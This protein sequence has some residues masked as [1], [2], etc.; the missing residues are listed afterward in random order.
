MDDPRWLPIVY[1]LGLI[2]D[3]DE[4]KNINIYDEA[5]WR[6]C[7]L[8]RQD[9]EAQ[10]HPRGGAG[11]PSAASGGAA[12]PLAAAQPVDCHAYG[13]LDTGHDL[14]QDAMEPRGVRALARRGEAA[15][16]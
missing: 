1:G 6:R 9:G 3:E 4:L 2:E 15:A 13:G 12:V 8:D 11:R 7:N 5:L 14:R 16:R 10:Y